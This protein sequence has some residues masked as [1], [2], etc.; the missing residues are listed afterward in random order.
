MEDPDSNAL[1]LDS[2][3]NYSRL[4]RKYETEGNSTICNSLPDNVSGYIGVWD[5]CMKLTRAL[6]RLNDLGFTGPFQE[7]P[8]KI[9]NYWMY[10]YLFNIIIKDQNSKRTHPVLLNFFT[11]W[12]KYTEKNNCLLNLQLNIDEFNDMYDLFNYATDYEKI[13]LH[14][15]GNSYICTQNVKDYIKKGDDIYTKVNG[16]CPSDRS[17]YCSVLKDI[18]KANNGEALSSLH[19][20]LQRVLG[21]PPESETT[22]FGDG[23]GEMREESKGRE[24]TPQS[25]SAAMAVIFPVFGSVLIYFILH[26]FTPFGSWINKHFLKKKFVED[27]IYKDETNES[28]ENTLEYVNE[29]YYNNQHNIGYQSL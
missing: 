23:T 15:A 1:L 4:D 26:K 24:N 21:L 6:S 18:E 20:D 9:V 29:N 13:K 27:N 14:L 11:I 25:S 28:L 19:C 17:F 10:N 12:G 16:K 8:C 22:R 3:Y 7:D 2:K 5:L